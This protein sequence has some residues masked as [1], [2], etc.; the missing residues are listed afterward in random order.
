M[1]DE[2]LESNAVEFSVPVDLRSAGLTEKRF[3]LSA[4]AQECALIAKRLGIPAVGKLEGEVS[5]TAS[6]TEIKA[7]GM[8]RAELTRECV[9]S[10]EEMAETIDEPFEVVFARAPAGTEPESL[11][12]QLEDLDAP[13]MHIGEVFDVGEFLT[14]QLALAMDP[15]PRK[16]GAQSLADQYGEDKPISPFAALAEQGRD[17]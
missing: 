15:F 12:E 8:L 11:E 10:L 4:N 16:P 1:S 9:A 3:E 2:S 13:D 5:L 14:Q 7:S 6:K 17:S